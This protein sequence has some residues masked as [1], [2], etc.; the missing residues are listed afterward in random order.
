MVLSGLSDQEKTNIDDKVPLLGDV[1]VVQYLFRN[2]T[3]LS[4][5]KTVLIL[6]TPRQATLS[7]D[8]GNSKDPEAD[9]KNVNL[10]KLEKDTSWMRP[11]SNLRGI[12]YHLG[13]YD[14]FNQFRKSDIMLENWAGE[15]TFVDVIRRTLE[16]FY[17]RYGFEKNS[18][19]EL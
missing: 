18:H 9:I 4:A 2:N 1:P 5:K 13:K 10:T 19:S 16:Y 12:V 3:K 15:G 17:I 7:Y 14:F 8:D 11:S 6:L